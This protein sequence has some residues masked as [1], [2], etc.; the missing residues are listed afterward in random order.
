VATLESTLFVFDVMRES[1]ERT[2][3][4]KLTTGEPVNLERALSMQRRLGGHFVTGHVDFCAEIT[5]ADRLSDERIITMAYPHEYGRCIVP[6]GSIAV[7]GISLT[8][9][10]VSDSTFSVYLIPHTIG[11]TTLGIRQTGDTVNIEVDILARYVLKSERSEYTSRVDM[12]FL[13]EHGFA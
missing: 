10:E 13:A 3:I 7:D 5:T 6:K 12:K 1:A 9:G 2:T 8:V 11:H 4:T